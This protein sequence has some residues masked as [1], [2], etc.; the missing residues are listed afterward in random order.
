MEDCLR[1]V[2]GHQ[3]NQAFLTNGFFMIPGL[4]LRWG[5]VAT[6]RS[7]DVSLLNFGLKR[8]LQNKLPGSS[9][10]PARSVKRLLYKII[11]I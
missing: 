3:H 10:R 8:C 9:H 7:T 2:V 5:I 11:L 1:M 6:L 4:K